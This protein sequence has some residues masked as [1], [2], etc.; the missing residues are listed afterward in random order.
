LQHKD[1]GE[2]GVI[3]FRKRNYHKSI[4]ITPSTKLTVER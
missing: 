4:S 2:S 1:S 3:F